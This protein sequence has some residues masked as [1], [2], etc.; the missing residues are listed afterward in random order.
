MCSGW[1]DSVQYVVYL[2]LK[3]EGWCWTVEHHITISAWHFRSIGSL[4]TDRSPSSFHSV[5]I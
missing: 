5:K 3:Y 1:I 2:V 4:W